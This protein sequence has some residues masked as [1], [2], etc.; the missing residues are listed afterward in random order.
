MDVM[1]IATINC[2]HCKNM[3]KNSITCVFPTGCILRKIIPTS[4]K[5]S[6]SGIRRIWWWMMK[7]C[8]GGNRRKQNCTLISTSRLE[9]FMY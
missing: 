6:V 8:L 5:N 7:L 2:S 3:E 9:F 4:F 1:I